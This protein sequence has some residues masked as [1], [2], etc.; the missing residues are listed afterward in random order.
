MKWCHYRVALSLLIAPILLIATLV[1]VAGAQGFPQLPAQSGS[2]IP[3]TFSG[4]RG[5]APQSYLSLGNAGAGRGDS[6][7]ASSRGMFSAGYN[8]NRYGFQGG[9]GTNELRL[10]YSVPFRISNGDVVN[11][12]TLVYLTNLNDVLQTF[13]FAD[14]ALRFGGTWLKRLRRGSYV[15]ARGEYDPT[16]RQGTWYS[17]GQA[18]IEMF[19]FIGSDIASLRVTYYSQSAGDNLIFTKTPTGYEV[20]ACY[21]HT[22]SAVGARLM[23]IAS[24]YDTDAGA[25][26]H[27]RGWSLRAS[28]SDRSGLFSL[29]GGTGYDSVVLNNYTVGAAIN[30]PF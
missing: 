19:Q 12:F 15:G 3:P 4:G 30:L 21:A 5:A 18:A 2:F 29:N 13:G 17:G 28:L 11:A 1:G 20:A 6:G 9:V 22:I 16:R 10:R 26:E 7:F 23:L 14:A 25:S 27:Q 8:Y 24:G